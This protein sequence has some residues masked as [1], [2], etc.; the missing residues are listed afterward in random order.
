MAEVVGE[1]LQPQLDNNI[2]TRSRIN[3]YLK[4][5]CGEDGE[6]LIFWNNSNESLM[7]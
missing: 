7:F 5:K 6:S 1:Y 3:K 4:V 2:S